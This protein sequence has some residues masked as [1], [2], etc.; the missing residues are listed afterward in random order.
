MERFENRFFPKSSK[1][2]FHHQTVFLLPFRYRIQL[3][4]NSSDSR[5]YRILESSKNPKII[6]SRA[7]YV[8]IVWNRLIQW[9]QAFWEKLYGKN[10]SHK[11]NVLFY[12]PPPVSKSLQRKMFYNWVGLGSKKSKL[13]FIFFVSEVRRH[14]K[15]VDLD[16]AWWL[17][18]RDYRGQILVQ[19]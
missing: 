2:I 4:S 7:I 18:T 1:K 8:L 6:H 11:R 19:T 10:L 12:G 3:R 13:Y 5:I 9:H 14:S 15:T 17:T 16:R